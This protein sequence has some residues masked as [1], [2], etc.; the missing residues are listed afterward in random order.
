MKLLIVEDE[1]MLADVI[2][3]RLEDE[4]FEVDMALDGEEGEFL[5]LSGTYDLIILDRMLPGIDGID[6]VRHIRD[7]SIV[8]PVLMLTARSAAG[9][10]LTE[11]RAEEE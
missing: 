10:R 5:A 9:E 7:Q 1:F 11:L 4:N 6:I 8:C 2:K 3:D